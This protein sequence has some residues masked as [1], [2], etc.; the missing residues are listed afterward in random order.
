[1]RATW[2]GARSGRISIVTLPLVVSNV[3]VSSGLAI[4]LP[5]T[6][7]SCASALDGGF[8]HKIHS[9]KF[10]REIGVAFVL[11]AALVRAAAARRAFAILG[12]E[13]IDDIHTGHDAPE[14]REAHAVEIAVVGKIDE[15][16]AGA[17]ARS[18]RCKRDHA[19]LVALG[20]RVIGNLRGAPARH[21]CGIAIDAELHHET[22]HDAEE[23]HV[24]VKSVLHEVV[25]TVGAFWRPGARYLNHEHALA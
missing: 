15:H 17:R 7:R 23:A 4:V 16:L 14:R 13:R 10:F 5:F 20:D 3:S 2:P 1:M 18:G 25:E 11:K 12:V 21:D 9:R 24:V 22:R 8:L 19:A 6:N